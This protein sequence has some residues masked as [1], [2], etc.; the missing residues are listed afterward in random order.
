MGLFDWLGNM[1]PDS[2]GVDQQLEQAPVLPQQEPFPSPQEWLANKQ[3]QQRAEEEYKARQQP[4]ESFPVDQQ[5]PQVLVPAASPQREFPSPQEWL[6]QKKQQEQAQSNPTPLENTTSAVYKVINTVM[7]PA[8]AAL[9]AFSWF[10]KPRGAIAGAID[11]YQDGGSIVEGAKKGFGENTSYKETFSEEY[12]KEHPTRAAITGFGLDA[13]ADPMWLVP[14]VKIASLIARGSKATKLTDKVI[15]PAAKAFKESETGQKAIAWAEDVAG[16]NRVADEQ[17]DFN[18]ARARDQVEGQDY[19][20]AVKGLKKQYGNQANVLTDYV[21]AAERPQNLLTLTP[22]MRTDIIDAVQSRTAPDLIRQGVFSRDDAFNALRD[23]NKDIPD[24]LLQDAQRYA[25]EYSH[26]P[27]QL[28]PDTVYRDE[29][30]KAIPGQNL[31]N[32]IKTIGDSFSALNKR[33]SDNLLQAGRLSDGQYVRFMDGEHLRRSFEQYENPEKFL[34][35]VRKNGTPEEFRQVYQA[36][37]NSK[38][39]GAQGFSAAHRVQMKDFIGRQNLSDETMKK[40]GMITDPEYRIMDTINRS[41]KALREEEFLQRVATAWG[42]TADEAADLS[43]T[44]PARRQYVPIPD[45]KGYGALAG[46][47]VPRD[48]AHQVLKTTGTAPDNINKTWQKMVSWWKVEKLANPASVMRNFYS[49]IPMANVFGGVPFQQMPKYMGKILMA[50]KSAGKNHPVLRELRESGILS[51]EWSRSE[52]NNILSGNA[53]KRFSSASSAIGKA[54]AGLELAAEKGMK[55]FGLPDTFWRAVV[56]SYHRDKGKTAKEAAKIANKALLDY[57]SAPDWMNTLSKSGAIPFIKFPA[58]AGA[59]TAKALYK[60]PAQVTKYT[61]AQNQ[62]NNEDR[63][64]I[65]PDYMKAKTLLPLGNGTRM[66]D[67]KP[68]QVQNNLDLSY[69][70]PFASDVSLGNPASDLYRLATTGKNGLG[71]DVI[72]PGMTPDDKTKAYAQYAYNALGPAFPLPGN[73]AG[74]KLSDAFNGRGDE[75]GRQFDIPSAVAQVM[76]GL[77]NVPINTAEMAE[78]KIKA[79]TME[80]NN[81]QARIN[82]IDKDPRLTETQKK[83]KKAAYERQYK[84]LET[85]IKLTEAAAKREKQR[86]GI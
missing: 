34:E 60:N 68:Q 39:P 85:Q 20:D 28:I 46:K 80:K 31:R 71:M 6:A 45:T 53:A 52:L 1:V 9:E 59:Q 15:N 29:M 82:Q 41:S 81:T 3:A 22:N 66:V 49:G 18:A 69:V 64:Q 21:Q 65:M 72:K 51:N 25:K 2:L 35:A 32:V 61:K 43:R 5:I 12:V 54:G 79:L 23:A 16:K 17:F 76:L 67:G 48:V 62:V 24:Y 74:S 83:E 58:M 33:Y 47:W 42:K 40:L 8:T 50:Y 27:A 37:A 73:Y 13:L 55:A 4:I 30:L 44:L 84:T 77:K 86:A 75:K 70:L 14:P 38:A 7:E 57:S 63:E 78:Q 10:D 11:A 56:Y 19:V 26:G 36:L